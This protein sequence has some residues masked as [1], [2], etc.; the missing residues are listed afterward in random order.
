M[1]KLIKS[2]GEVIENYKAIGLKA[3]QKAVGGYIEAVYTDKYV[4]FCNEEGL[5]YQLP[6]NLEVSALCGKVIVGDCVVM[7]QKESMEEE[8]GMD[9]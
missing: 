7:T 3:K 4:I 6:M 2:N 1:A 9:S 8:R 5:L